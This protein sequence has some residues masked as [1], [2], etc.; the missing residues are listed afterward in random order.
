MTRADV[1]RRRCELRIEPYRR[2]GYLTSEDAL[3]FAQELRSDIA[4]IVFLDPPFNLGKDYGF[5]TQL[6]RGD[7]GW[8]ENYMKMLVFEMVRVLRSGGAFFLYH[9]PFWASRWS[10]DLHEV[11]QF[12]HWIAIA[13]KNG[14]ARGERLYPAHYALLYFTKGR[15][16]EFRRPRLQPKTCRHCG[17]LVKDCGGY[18]SIIQRKGINLS[19]VWDD[20]SPVRHRSRKHRRANELPPALTDRIVAIA[21]SKGGL[22]V[23]PFVGAGTS[24]VSAQKAGMRFVGNDLDRRCVRLCISRLQSCR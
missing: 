4:D 6:E 14:F 20:L 13:M 1:F 19:D 18:T 7:V 11:L 3:K 24:L 16:T 12:R 21:G 8:Y 15:P 17:N 23:D 22:L 10:R 2:K 9:L 5:A